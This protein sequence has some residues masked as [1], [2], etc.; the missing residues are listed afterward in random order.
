[1]HRYLTGLLFLTHLL[2]HPEAQTFKQ[3]ELLGW[4]TFA[5]IPWTESNIDSLFATGISTFLFETQTNGNDAIYLRKA[6]D[7][8]AELQTDHP[9]GLLLLINRSIPEKTWHKELNHPAILSKL[10]LPEKLPFDSI[11]HLPVKQAGIIAFS[12]GGSDLSYSSK[13]FLHSLSST[14]QSPV[15]CHKRLTSIHLDSLASQP[16]FSQAL[17]NWLNQNTDLSLIH[18]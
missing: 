14:T 8:L 7:K 16:S 4:N 10:I 17:T 18:I 11:R 9:H 1:M 6:F 2:F 12:P 13:K 15:N 5:G 3:S